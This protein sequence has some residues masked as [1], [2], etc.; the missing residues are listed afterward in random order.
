MEHPV[1]EDWYS[2]EPKQLRVL[3]TILERQE[4][5]LS[6]FEDMEQQLTSILNRLDHLD[7]NEKRTHKDS[8]EIHNHLSELK[9]LKEREINALL[10]EKIPFPF[11]LNKAQVLTPLSMSFRRP[12]SSSFSKKEAL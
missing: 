1:I 10:R 7:S 2:F 4:K 12:F 8:S 11:M 6:K 5:I 3:E 9:V